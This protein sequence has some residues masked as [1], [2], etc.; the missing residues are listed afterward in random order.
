MQRVNLYLLA[1]VAAAALAW[2][3][4]EPIQWLT[5]N[6]PRDAPVNYFSQSVLG[7]LVGGF[8][9]A[10][11][12]LAEALLR[13]G[14]RRQIQQQALGGLGIGL[15]GG[16]VGVGIGQLIYG[17][18][19]GLSDLL[20]AWLAPLGF[21]N[22]LL[23]RTVGWALLGALIGL[24]G[25]L[26]NSSPRRMA[27]G[28]KGGLLGGALGGFLFQ[29]LLF[30]LALPELSRA[31]GFI[32]VGGFTGLGIGLA[33]ELS[34]Q[35]WVRVMVGRN[36][37]REYP[38]DKAVN[39]LG[40]DELSDVP[41]FGDTSV[42]KT[43]ATIRGLSGRWFLQ[44]AGQGG[45]RVNG[46]PVKEQALAD[47]DRIEIGSFVIEFHEKLGRSRAFEPAD[48]VSHRSPAAAPEGAGGLCAYCGTPRNPLTGACACTPV[49]P[50][51]AAGSRVPAAEGPGPLA[52]GAPPG[53]A[54][55]VAGPRLTCLNGPAAGRSFPLLASG[56]ALGREADRQVV[57]SWD[58]TV[59]RRHALIYSEGGEW[60][61]TDEGSS[62]G[63]FVNE[64]R[65]TTSTLKPGDELRIGATRFRFEE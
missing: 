21:A 45:T 10:G 26:V 25:G 6:L 51:P 3:V 29:S 18:W 2:L 9:T 56:T 54:V 65:V 32:A 12:G 39:T 35:A 41:L 59:S 60:R 34:K 27:N 11:I 28:L 22:E 4:T 42:G 49:S 50:R 7:A 1:G 64:T 38:L 31:I 46:R 16:F 40:R 24:A 14:A 61:V 43:H 58:S 63:T 36:E 17:R 52:G 33:Q 13:G 62:N 19:A 30:I 37:G 55:G 8:I 44:D 20:R 47:G 53:L 15:V 23:S 57:V 48:A 5:P